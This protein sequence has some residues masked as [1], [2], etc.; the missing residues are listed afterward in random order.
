MNYQAKIKYVIA[1]VR[2]ILPKVGA[3][4]YTGS[5]SEND[6]GYKFLFKP[7]SWVLECR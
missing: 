7:M 1:S 2:W 4:E 3:D 6:V 5:E